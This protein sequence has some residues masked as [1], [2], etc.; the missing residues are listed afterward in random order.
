MTTETDK[1]PGHSVTQKRNL[2]APL[3]KRLETLPW[4]ADPFQEIAGSP[5]LHI[6]EP[7][8]EQTSFGHIALVARDNLGVTLLQ[9]VDFGLADVTTTREITHIETSW[10]LAGCE[11]SKAKDHVWH[12]AR[13]SRSRLLCNA[14]RAT[15]H[16]TA[17]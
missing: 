16:L 1:K 7:Q 5:L 10:N 13:S 12:E 11:V 4:C 15:N 3:R 8:P 2:I 6:H 17:S 14:D 9:A